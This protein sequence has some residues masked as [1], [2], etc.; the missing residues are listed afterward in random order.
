MNA[1]ERCE[2]ELPRVDEVNLKDAWEDFPA[3]QAQGRKPGQKDLTYGRAKGITWGYQS[4]KKASE[5]RDEKNS[6][7]PDQLNW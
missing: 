1:I 7:T 5:R 6:S 2:H 3:P 4:L